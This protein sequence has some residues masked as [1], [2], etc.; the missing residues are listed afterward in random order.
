VIDGELQFTGYSREQLLDALRHID[1]FRYPKNFANAQAELTARDFASSGTGNR[2]SACAVEPQLTNLKS[3]STAVR[4]LAVMLIIGGLLGTG[5][6]VWVGYL[7]AIKDWSIGGLDLLA[8]SLLPLSAVAGFWLWRDG[9][10]ARICARV[11]FALQIPV[12]EFH[13]L[14]YEYYTGIAAPLRHGPG[15]TN[16]TMSIGG[17]ATMG[18]DPNPVGY[19]I[20][21]NLVAVAALI[22]LM[23]APRLDKQ[24]P[25][26]G[27]AARA[28]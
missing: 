19:V 12:L 10:P 27:L 23:Y 18:F 22:I 15:G 14:S 20:G 1:Q 4:V 6:A 13:G 21:A 26:D 17:S 11:L 25:N 24:T 2:T 5:L 9:R 16:F 3:A 28:P 8:F 7:F